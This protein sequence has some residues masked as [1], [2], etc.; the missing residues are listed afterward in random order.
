MGRIVSGPALSSFAIR[1]LCENV[2][3]FATIRVIRGL[4]LAAVM[5]RWEKTVFPDG[6]AENGSVVALCRGGNEMTAQKSHGNRRR[7]SR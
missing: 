2:A 3:L 4:A 1:R 5:L 7:D 6:P